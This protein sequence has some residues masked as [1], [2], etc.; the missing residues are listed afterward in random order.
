M[1]VM[2]KLEITSNAFPHGGTIPA[3]YT[4]G[5]KDLSCSIVGSYK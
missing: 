2:S 5:G 1:A 3:D 4:S